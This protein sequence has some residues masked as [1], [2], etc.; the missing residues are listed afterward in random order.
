MRAPALLVVLLVALA[1]R[2]EEQ[3]SADSTAQSSGGAAAASSAKQYSLADFRQ[4]RWLEGRWRG[5]LPNGDS[6]YEQYRWADDS[7]I[8]M[9]SFPDST[10]ARASDSARIS[11]R[12]GVVANEGATARWEATD[13]DSASVDFAPVRGA[14]NSFGWVRESSTRWTATLRSTDREG[15]PQ[16][17]VYRME[18]INRA[19]N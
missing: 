1:C 19:A 14:S 10:F 7:T 9:H 5:G 18:R 16:Q 3:P 6:F 15:R 12:N 4:L 11:L 17:T 2:S 8:V 13:L